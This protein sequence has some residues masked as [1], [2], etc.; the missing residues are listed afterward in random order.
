MTPALTRRPRP[1]PTR[2]I[3]G[4]LLIGTSVALVSVVALIMAP[5]MR[6]PRFVDRLTISNPTVYGLEVEVRGEGSSG[7]LDVGPVGRESTRST[8]ELVDPGET[9]V[10]RF[11][12]GGQEVGGMAIRRDQLKAREWRLTVPQ[13]VGDRLAAAGL[14]PS[15][16]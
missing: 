5:A 2:N 1:A 8:F 15:A 12:H 16:R 14:G 9:W 6:L 4:N 13:E 11:S 3:G 7:W 10:F